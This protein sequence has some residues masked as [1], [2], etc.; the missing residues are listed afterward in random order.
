VS[1]R[2]SHYVT[3]D[4][5]DCCTQRRSHYLA[6]TGTYTVSI[7]RTDVRA[8]DITHRITNHCSSYHCAADCIS[9]DGSSDFIT[10]NSFTLNASYYLFSNCFNTTTE[11]CSDHRPN[12][13]T[14]QRTIRKSDKVPIKFTEYRSYAVSN[15]IVANSASIGIAHH[16]RTDHSGTI[17]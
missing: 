16:I 8:N 5:S 6:D 2:E 7:K 15:D 14:N 1:N 11:Q 9:D 13:G 17:K 4:Q 10:D 3:F 12:G